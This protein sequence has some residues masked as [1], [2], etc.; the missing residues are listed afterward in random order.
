MNKTVYKT[1]SHSPIFSNHSSTKSRKKKKPLKKQDCIRKI[2]L[3]SKK[4]ISFK[5]ISEKVGCTK[6][7]VK[8]TIAKLI[9]K[10][11]IVK[12]PTEY[13]CTKYKKDRIYCGK[14]LYS[15]P[16]KSSQK[17]ENSKN[18]SDKN[19]GEKIPPITSRINLDKSKLAKCVHA[20]EDFSKR[21]F[22]QEG[23][24][25]EKLE[26]LKRYGFED[27]ADK[28][29]RWWFRDLR[30]LHSA[31]KLLQKKLARGYSCRDPFQFLCYLLKHGTFGYRRH[32]ARNLSLAINRPTLDRVEPYM[33]SPFVANGYEALKELH[34][35]HDLDIAFTNLQKLLR[36]G[37]SHLAMSADV[38]LKRLKLP[39]VQ[40]TNAFL[41]HIVSMKE[42]VDILKKKTA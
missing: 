6:R 12:S 37:F 4:P 13:L 14:N 8:I 30:R 11:K 20:C 35:K 28:A 40:N 32:C 22:T 41:H 17:Q 9:A 1:I 26:I 38:M 15:Y 10:G 23:F 16:K 2:L 25:T 36:K 19:T 31:L 3:A 18:V 5:E 33:A 34:K 29:P 39:G 7:Y 42:P 27:L 24:R 21:K